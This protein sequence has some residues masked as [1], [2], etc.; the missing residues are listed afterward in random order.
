MEL[1]NNIEDLEEDLV[2]ISIDEGRNSSFE[3]LRKL[4]KRIS[5]AL[6]SDNNFESA[7]KRVKNA[8]K[9]RLSN[10]QGSDK[11][12]QNQE[13]IDTLLEE[14]GIMTDIEALEAE[15][16]RNDANKQRLL[17]EALSSNA[18]LI[19]EKE[20]MQEIINDLKIK[21]VA[22]EK[23]SQDYQTIESE[24]NF[25]KEATQKCYGEVKRLSQ[26]YYARVHVKRSFEICE[27]FLRNK[28]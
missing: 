6:G 27:N 21:N 20:D 26:I 22:L 15:A 3:S 11:Q 16:K 28:Q 2:N 18:L 13:T 7:M 10:Y 8:Q 4:Q 25:Q 23:K 19:K 5:I 12:T 9:N 1:V 17:E 14:I 24:L